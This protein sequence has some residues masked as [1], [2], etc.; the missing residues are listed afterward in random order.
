MK[1]FHRGMMGSSFCCLLK[2]SHCNSHSAVSLGYTLNKQG[3]ITWPLHFFPAA[4]GKKKKN[5]AKLSSRACLGSANSLLTKRK[6]KN[7]KPGWPTSRGFFSFFFFLPLL[8]IFLCVCLAVIRYA[9]RFRLWLKDQQRS[10][11]AAH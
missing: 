2:S 3:P 5:S 8:C 11:V 7:D 6:K 4:K 9:E 10:L 1:H